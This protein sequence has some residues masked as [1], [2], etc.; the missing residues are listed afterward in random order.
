MVRLFA[1][2]GEDPNEV[3]SVNSSVNITFEELEA[4]RLVDLLELQQ[5]EAAFYMGVSKKVLWKD[6]RSAR[7]KA[8]M[9]LVYGLGISLDGGSYILRDSLDEPSH[10]EDASKVQL[11]KKNE[12]DLLECEMQIMRSRLDDLRYRIEALKNN[13]DLD[14]NP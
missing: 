9:A 5:Q 7:R 4:L 8:A 3:G 13:K 6:L 14:L 11:M 10:Q 2:V 12:L 1:P